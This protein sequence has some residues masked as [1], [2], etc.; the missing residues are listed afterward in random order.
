MTVS[1]VSAFPVL[2]CKHEPSHQTLK[3]NFRGEVILFSI[4]GLSMLP[5]TML[6]WNSETHSYVWVLGWKARITGQEA[7]NLNFNWCLVIPLPFFFFLHCWRFNL[8]PLGCADVRHM[9]QPCQPYSPLSYLRVYVS[10]HAHV[11]WSATARAWS[12]RDNLQEL[13]FSLLHSGQGQQVPFPSEPAPWFHPPFIYLA[14]NRLCIS[15]YCL[16]CCLPVK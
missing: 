2:D 11:H 16:L 8:S 7:W 1:P 9:A 13:V 10:A 4:W 3:F 6:A 5:C 14:W 12:L 15:N